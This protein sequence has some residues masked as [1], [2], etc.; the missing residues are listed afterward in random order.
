MVR[1]AQAVTG[2][3]V[4]YMVGGFHLYETPRGMLLPIIAEMHQLGVDKVLPAHCTGDDAIAL[5]RT[6]YGENFVEGG[7]GRTMTIS[8]K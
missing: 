7:V 6:E 8:G 2:G 5:F 1:Q 3:K 4:A